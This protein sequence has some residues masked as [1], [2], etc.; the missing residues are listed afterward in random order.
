MPGFQLVSYEYPKGFGT[1]AWRILK[2]TS[3]IW[4]DSAPVPQAMTTNMLFQCICSIGRWTT[5]DCWSLQTAEPTRWDPQ[6]YQF[7]RWV[8]AICQNR[9]NLL[10]FSHGE[11][12]AP[13]KGPVCFFL[14]PAAGGAFRLPPYFTLILRAFGTL[15]GAEDI[16]KHLVLGFLLGKSPDLSDLI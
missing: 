13:D 8:S 14:R 6:I 3:L 5:Y 2:T 16:R 11:G 7:A 12:V 1:L 9:S 15:E 4:I 10:R